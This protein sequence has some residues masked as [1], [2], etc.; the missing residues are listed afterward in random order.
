MSQSES[1]VLHVIFHLVILVLSSSWASTQ[2]S[3]S[4]LPATMLRRQRHTQGSSQQVACTVCA[5]ILLSKP[6]TCY[7]DFCVSERKLEMV[8]LNTQHLL[9]RDLLVSCWNLMEYFCKNSIFSGCMLSWRFATV[10][11]NPHNSSVISCSCTFPQSC[12]LQAI[13]CTWNQNDMGSNPRST[14]TVQLWASCMTFPHLSNGDSNLTYFAGL[15][16]GCSAA[17]VRPASLVTTQLP[18]QSK[19]PE[20]ETETSTVQ[21]I[22]ELTEF[23][24]KCRGVTPHG[25]PQKAGGRWQKGHNSNLTTLNTGGEA[26]Y[27]L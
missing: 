21:W 13:Y 16:E 1:D 19:H 25:R 3:G 4:T 15:L 23:A 9:Y 5:Y 18:N 8:W 6:I 22:G 2:S 7:T 12:T 17:P 24:A 11:A 27:H 14:L 26:A 20:I 10:A